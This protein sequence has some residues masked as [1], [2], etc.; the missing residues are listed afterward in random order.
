MLSLLEFTMRLDAVLARS[1]QAI[2]NDQFSYENWHSRAT[3]APSITSIRISP[4]QL[5]G[6]SLFFTAAYRT[7][8]MRDV[9]VVPS[10]APKASALSADQPEELIVLDRL[11]GE[12]VLRGALVFMR[13]VLDVDGGAAVG[14]RLPI[15]I[16]LG[17][18]YPRGRAWREQLKLYPEGYV[19]LTV[20]CRVVFL[21]V[22]SASDDVCCLP[23][24]HPEW[25]PDSVVQ[26]MCMYAA[27]CSTLE[28]VNCQYRVGL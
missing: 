23:K 6:Q 1:L 8:A 28:Q 12:A 25:I 19:R 3:I 14:T 15:C 24:A 11:C 7:P 13:G 18:T 4:G 22:V 27:C 10:A 26:S 16:W 20:F 9:V 17:A 21:T 5:L 2:E